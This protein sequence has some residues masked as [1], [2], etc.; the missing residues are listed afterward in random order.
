MDERNDSKV[1]LNLQETSRQAYNRLVIF[2]A[3]SQNYTYTLDFAYSPT[4]SKSLP[5]KMTIDLKTSVDARHLGV[6]LS[7]Q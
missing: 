7:E 2:F 6:S 1:F 5:E 4:F 3:Y